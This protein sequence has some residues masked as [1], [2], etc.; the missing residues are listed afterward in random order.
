MIVRNEAKNAMYSDYFDDPNGI[1]EAMKDDGNESEENMDDIESDEVSDNSQEMATEGLNNNEGDHANDDGPK[2]T[3]EK[4]QEKVGQGQLFTVG[5][6]RRL[7]LSRIIMV[8][9]KKFHNW[10]AKEIF[11]VQGK[12]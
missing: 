7:H 11:T 2:S 6:G 1:S 8:V 3:L 12:G 4:Q 9:P 5:G 10:P